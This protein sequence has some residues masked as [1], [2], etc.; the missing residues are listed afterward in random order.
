MVT[1]KRS[2]LT[3]APEGGVYLDFPVAL[4]QDKGSQFP[5]DRR[6]FGS[7]N[8]A[9]RCGDLDPAGNRIPAI[10]PVAIPNEL[11]RLL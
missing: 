5:P 4:P 3:L 6:P 7:Q 10:Y 9:G 8:W 11:F 1:Y 2:R